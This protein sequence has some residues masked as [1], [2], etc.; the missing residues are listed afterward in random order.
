MPNLLIVCPVT[1]VMRARLDPRFA[2]HDLRAMDDPEGWLAAHGAEIDYVLTDGHLGLKP[3]YFD[4]LPNL[5]AI[6]SYGV[7]YDAID[8]DLAIARGVVVAHTPDVLNAEVATTAL[9]LYL[10]CFRNFRA[11]AAHAASGG[12]ASNG[13][14]PLARSADQRR[15]GILGLGRIGKAVVEKLQPF[16]PTILYTGRSKQDVPHKYVPSLVYLASQVEVLISIAPGGS[17]THHLINA[18]VLSALGPNG[19]LINVGRGSV[20][21]EEALISALASGQ[22]GWAGLDVFEDEPNIP[23]ALRD[24]PRVTVTPHIGSATIET[25]RAMGD[26]AIDNLLDHV[27]HGRPR[28]PVPECR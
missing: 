20:V 15:I 4:R 27:D 10:D 24:H 7:G 18:D 21:D 16:S 1:D 28:T 11:Q 3:A 5:R 2:C 22:L 25:R 23:Q 14:L 9:M 6:S 26:L 19:T 12:W 17:A 8:T 13:S